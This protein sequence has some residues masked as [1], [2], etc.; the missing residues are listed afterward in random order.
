MDIDGKT[1]STEKMVEES[2]SALDCPVDRYG[3]I[4]G[5]SNYKNGIEL[6]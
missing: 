4:K 2:G 6:P 1:D 3:R 5:S